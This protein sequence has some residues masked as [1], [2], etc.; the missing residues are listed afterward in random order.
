MGNNAT[1]AY[2]GIFAYHYEGSACITVSYKENNETYYSYLGVN[3]EEVE[4]II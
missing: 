1:Q 2:F 3:K 4:Y